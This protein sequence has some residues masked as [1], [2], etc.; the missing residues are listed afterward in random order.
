MYIDDIDFRILSEL[1]EDASLAN[2]ALAERVH[3][4]P[5][6]ALR[7][8]RALREAGVVEAIVAV[9]SPAKLGGVQHAICDVSLDV[10]NADAFDRFEAL[11]R[12]I[13]EVTQCYRTSPGVDFVVFLTLKDM[14]HYQS[15]SQT[16]FTAANNVRNVRTRFVTT[17]SKFTSRIPLK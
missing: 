16:L 13:A 11:V 6:T 1:Q 17:R 2:L 8:V 7:R 9:L 5:A 15:L 3:V 12:D 4:S 14:A 10:Q